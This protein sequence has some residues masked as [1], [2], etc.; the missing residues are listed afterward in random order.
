M[1]ESDASPTASLKSLPVKQ[2]F[3]LRGS[4]MTRLETFAGAS[5]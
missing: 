4:N 1:T 2:G 3:R 5:G